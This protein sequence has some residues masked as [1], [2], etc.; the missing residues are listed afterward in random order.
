MK[1]KELYSWLKLVVLGT[2]FYGLI[3]STLKTVAKP[4]ITAAEY[5]VHD[6]AMAM[7][8]A[9]L[10]YHLGDLSLIVSDWAKW[11]DSYQFVIDQNQNFI[12]T[13]LDDETFRTIGTNMIVFF[14]TRGEA[15]YKKSV[16]LE[17]GQIADIPSEIYKENSD[18]PIYNDVIKVLSSNKEVTKT[19]RTRN[20]LL[21]YTINPILPTNGEGKPGGALMMAKYLSVS[22]KKE[23]KS[24]LGLDFEVYDYINTDR[25]LQN[26]LVAYGQ[27]Q[28]VTETE[29]SRKKLFR[30][31]LGR[32][33]LYVSFSYPRV[34]LEAYKSVIPYVSA[35][36]TV[37]FILIIAAFGKKFSL[38]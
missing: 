20:G 8:S 32:P 10:N 36:S 31:S 7:I 3:S 26:K 13:N 17:N 33:A 35:V 14:N 23:M 19:F 1:Y 6:T 12:K 18:K 22:D 37:M 28:T 38:F 27:V 5:R 2:I 34:F 24:H 21:V 29:I 30:D 16:P 4:A 25:E 11:D 15:V 9:S